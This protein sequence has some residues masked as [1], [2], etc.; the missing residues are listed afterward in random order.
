MTACNE[1]VKIR[2][3]PQVVITPLE[4]GVLLLD[5]ETKFFFSVNDSGW[6][7]LQLLEQGTAMEDILL[8]CQSWGLSEDDQKGVYNFLHKLE[9]NSLTENFTGSSS[10]CSMEMDKDWEEPT[11]D[12]YEEP[13]EKIV[14]SAF[15]PSVPLA[16]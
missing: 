2:L 4:K 12:R 13:L 8:Q 7:L 11:I 5:L 9:E 6:L 1:P 10:R 14:T 16:E 15:D 3:N